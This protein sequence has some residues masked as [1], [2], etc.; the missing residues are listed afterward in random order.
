M[1]KQLRVIEPFFT[2]DTDDV[3][4]LNEDGTRYISLR[5]E[6]YHQNGKDGDIKSVYNASFEISTSYAEELV[7]EGYLEEIAEKTKFVNVFDEINLLIEKYEDELKNIDEDM[8][9]LPACIKVEKTTVLENILK[10]LYHLKDL[11]K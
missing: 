7:K 6:E 5:K 1:T 4:E 11:R 10:V 3:F 8:A 2:V 9:T